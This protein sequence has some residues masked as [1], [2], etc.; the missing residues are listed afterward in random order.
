MIK[1]IEVLK[2]GAAMLPPQK[3]QKRNSQSQSVARAYRTVQVINVE[4]PQ[5]KL[6]Q[7]SLVKRTK[8]AD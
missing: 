2:I 3:T 1:M 7:D 5:N 6:T 4:Q 8:A